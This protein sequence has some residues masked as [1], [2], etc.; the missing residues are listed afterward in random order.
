MLSILVYL[1]INPVSAN[2]CAVHG[3]RSG[4]CYDNCERYCLEKPWCE[5]SHTTRSSWPWDRNFCGWAWQAK[6]VCRTCPGGFCGKVRRMIDQ[7]IPIARKNVQTRIDLLE[8]TLGGM[9]NADWTNLRETYVAPVM[10]SA[11]SKWSGHYGCENAWEKNDREWATLQQGVS[12]WIFYRWDR[13]VTLH[14]MLFRNRCPTGLDCGDTKRMRLEFSDGSNLEIDFTDRH[15]ENEILLPG[16]RTSTV[17]MRVIDTYSSHDNGAQYIR[18]YQ[19]SDPTLLVPSTCTASSKWSDDYSCHNAYEN[20]GLNWATAT[21]GVGSWIE[22]DFGQNVVIRKIVFQN[23]VCP[24]LD[25]GDT[26][27]GTLKFDHSVHTFDVHNRHGVN[28][29]WIQAVVT[30]KVRFRVDSVYSSVDNGAQILRFYGYGK[31]GYG[32]FGEGVVPYYEGN[33]IGSVA[34]A[35]V[36]DCKAWCE[37]R[38]NCKSFARCDDHK[39]CWF[40]DLKLTG[41]ESA[42]HL[43]RCTTYFKPDFQSDNDGWKKYFG[44]RN[45]HIRKPFMLNVLQNMRRYLGD[46]GYSSSNMVQLVAKPQG[47][48]MAR[49]SCSGGAPCYGAI[50][51]RWPQKIGFN[52]NV[53]SPSLISDTTVEKVAALII[54]ELSHSTAVGS[55]QNLQVTGHDIALTPLAVGSHENRG[56]LATRDWTYDDNEVKN[57]AR[58]YESGRNCPGGG[59]NNRPGANQYMDIPLNN[60]ATY[61]YWILNT[62]GSSCVSGDML[63]ESESSGPIKVGALVEGMKIRGKDAHGKSQWCTVQ[64]IY[65]NGMGTLFGNFTEG[66]LVLDDSTGMVQPSGNS[67]HENFGARYTIFTDCPVM[68][69]KDGEL[70]TPLA[71]TFCGSRD[72]SWSEYLVLWKAIQKV[73]SDTGIFWFHLDETFTDCKNTTLCG[74]LTDWRDALPPVCESLMDCASSQDDVICDDFEEEAQTFFDRYVRAERVEEIKKS[75]AE[76]GSI[77]QSVKDSSQNED[78]LWMIVAC[79]LAVMMA[80]FVVTWRCCCQEKQDEDKNQIAAV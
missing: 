39:L 78:N 1:L 74:N 35:N 11:S 59:Y 55:Y 48:S 46:I 33:H 72:F 44:N 24:G 56:F 71:Q 68:E 75:Y 60:A 7:A 79:S 80:I 62:G 9:G 76:Y 38:S 16:K 47:G 6:C 15:G 30:Q 69:N 2:V 50:E 14:K 28:N 52:V 57:Y 34:F 37:R 70:F 43:G 65:F 53:N 31:S 54:H 27:R 19:H 29:E 8:A 18:F 36:G 58:C 49:M 4:N 5:L 45:N 21:E 42:R 20:N 17:M 22:Y 41:K 64:D 61:E 25:C 23:R 67:S 32:K 10:C 12:S 73:V 63:V 13:E 51:K 26:A 77:S 3:H 40:K 66:H